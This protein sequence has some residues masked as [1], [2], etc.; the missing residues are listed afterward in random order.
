MQGWDGKRFRQAWGGTG[1]PCRVVGVRGRW[2]QL[3]RWVDTRRDRLAGAYTL[4]AIALAVTGLVAG[5]LWLAGCA[6][7]FAAAAIV[8]RYHGRNRL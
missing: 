3:D 2:R 4:T 7:W 8:L 5:V 6:A 1:I